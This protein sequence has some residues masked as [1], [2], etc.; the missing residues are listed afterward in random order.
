MFIAWLSLT[1]VIFNEEAIVMFRQCRVG[2]W[3]GCRLLA[4]VGDVLAR[5]AS[6]GPQLSSYTSNKTPQTTP[7]QQYGDTYW[8]RCSESIIIGAWIGLT[9]DLYTRNCRYL[10]DWQDIDKFADEQI[11]IEFNSC[12]IH[13]IKSMHMLLVS[14]SKKLS[15]T[16]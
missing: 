10:C 14:N 6:A 5:R 11:L 1:T 4:S 15:W 9:Q 3:L 12:C 7:T 13:S 2:Y 16:M 8:T